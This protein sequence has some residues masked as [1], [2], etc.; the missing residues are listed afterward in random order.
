M[1][2]R[3][4]GVVAGLGDVLQPLD[5]EPVKGA[6]DDGEEVVQPAR[7]HGA[8]DEHGDDEIGDADEHEQHGDADA[9]RLQQAE[10]NGADHHRVG[11]VD[12]PKDLAWRFR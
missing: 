6:E 3:D 4:D 9:E 7:R 1:V 10:E 2:H 8:G 12:V 11:K 5:F